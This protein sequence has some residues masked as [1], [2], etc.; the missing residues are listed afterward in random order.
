MEGHKSFHDA[1]AVGRVGESQVARWLTHVEGWSILPAY[2]I[3]IPSG[4]GP[5]LFTP[6]ENLIVPDIL[7]MKYKKRLLLRWHEVKSKS[8]FTWRYT[9][10]PPDW[11]TGIDLR[12][13]LDYIKVQARTKIDVYILFLHKGSIPLESD[14]KHGSPDTCP[15][16][17]FGQTLSYLMA[18]EHH[19]DSYNDGR[20]D[21]PMVYWNHSDLELLATVEQVQTLPVSLWKGMSA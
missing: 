8:R 2:D 9:G 7:A 4:K 10:K 14:L 11:Q 18:H 16:G 13:Y 6:D 12:H 5:Q 20:R 19:R 17:L 21:C 3:E 1:Y 15:I